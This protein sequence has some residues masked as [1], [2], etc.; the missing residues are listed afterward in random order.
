MNLL[1]NHFDID[2][3]VFANLMDAIDNPR[4]MQIFRTYIDKDDIDK[5]KNIHKVE[6]IQSLL[7]SIPAAIKRDDETVYFMSG[8]KHQKGRLPNINDKIRVIK[9][10]YYFTVVGNEIIS[11]LAF[12]ILNGAPANFQTPK[13]T[14]E[15]F[16]Q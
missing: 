6:I 8:F 1:L 2:S 10:K 9:G 12:E 7:Y 15:A 4:P 14:I 13:E 3:N 16:T 5:S 11:E